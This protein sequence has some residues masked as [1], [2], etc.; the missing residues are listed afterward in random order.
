MPVELQIVAGQCDSANR[1]VRVRR[2]GIRI[3]LWALDHRNDLRCWVFRQCRRTIERQRSR[4]VFAASGNA[5]DE[6][7]AV[8]EF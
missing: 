4:V 6:L 5:P 1:S 2:D 3:A 7:S 8:G